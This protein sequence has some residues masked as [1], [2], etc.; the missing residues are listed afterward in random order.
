MFFVVTQPDSLAA[1]G[2]ALYTIGSAL[3]AAP[4]AG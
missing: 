1:A 4:A 2:P 3:A